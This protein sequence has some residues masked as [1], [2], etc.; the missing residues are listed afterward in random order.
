MYVA[1]LLWNL[2]GSKL[3]T[4]ALGVRKDRSL[5]RRASAAIITIGIRVY[6]LG[7]PKHIQAV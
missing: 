2:P 3:A 4:V 6:S 5:G 1:G 7:V